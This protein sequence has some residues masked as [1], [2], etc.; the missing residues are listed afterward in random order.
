MAHLRLPQHPLLVKLENHGDLGPGAA[1]AQ[2]L[3]HYS[4][5]PASMSGAITSGQFGRLLESYSQLPAC[6]SSYP[7]EVSKVMEVRALLKRRVSQ[8]FTSLSR[9]CGG[10]R[11]R[12]R[13]IYLLLDPNA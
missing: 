8:S 2:H 10:S 3:P 4:A 1:K 11:E 13:G 7:G 12:L 6:Q 5:Q 9:I